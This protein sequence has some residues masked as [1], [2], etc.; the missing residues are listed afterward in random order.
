M[1]YLFVATLGA[2]SVLLE[3]LWRMVRNSGWVTCLSVENFYSRPTKH[4]TRFCPF[5]RNG[6]SCLL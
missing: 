4:E 5:D 3:W 2:V 6:R 1:K